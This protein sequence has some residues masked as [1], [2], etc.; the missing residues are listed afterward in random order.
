MR[1]KEAIT[2]T[3]LLSTLEH[4]NLPTIL[5]EGDD[6]LIIYRRL[7]T[8]FSDKEVSVLSV[9][10][11]ENIIS[12]FD[13]QDKLKLSYKIGFIADQDTWIVT[14]IP[15][16]Y[17]NKNIIFTTGYSIENDSL[18]DSNL[19]E[20][21]TTTERNIFFQNLTNFTAWYATE[22][23]RHITGESASIKKHPNDVLK[24]SHEPTIK[25]K[26][27]YDLIIEK[28]QTHIRGK[29]LLA[30]FL[31]SQ[32]CKNPNIKHHHTTILATVAARPGE[33]IQKIYNEAGEIFK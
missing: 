12:I 21:L 26:P 28:Y 19:L 31:L 20:T 4:S 8:I 6:D 16:Q 24:Q 25:A 9:G 30:L 1:K 3:E 13:Q 27:L 23:N 17:K 14:G 32:K 10:G 7:E 11:R 2:L 5:V 18:I 29:S 22:L 15:E 33:L